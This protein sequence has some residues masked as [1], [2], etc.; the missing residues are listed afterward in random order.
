MKL[1]LELKFCEN[2]SL[3]KGTFNET[4]YKTNF[5]NKMVLFFIQYL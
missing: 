2:L 5:K 1:C 4:E 3:V